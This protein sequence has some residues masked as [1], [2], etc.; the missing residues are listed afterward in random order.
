M[1]DI[2]MEERPVVVEKVNKQ[3]MCGHCKYTCGNMEELKQHM[4]DNHLNNPSG[5]LL[6]K[7]IDSSKFKS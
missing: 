6:T 2:E 7:N 1:A 3:V 5:L 4:K